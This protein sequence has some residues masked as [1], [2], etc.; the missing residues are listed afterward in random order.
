MKTKKQ[1]VEIEKKDWIFMFF[2]IIGLLITLNGFLGMQHSQHL[3]TS[4]AFASSFFTTLVGI[5]IFGFGLS[6]IKVKKKAKYEV[7][8]DAT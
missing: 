2:L 3:E 7:K 5:F 1:Y 4:Y 6:L 8:T